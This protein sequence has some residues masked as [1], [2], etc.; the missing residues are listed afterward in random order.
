MSNYISCFQFYFVWIFHTTIS[1]VTISDQSLYLIGMR[2][3]T[4]QETGWWAFHLFARVCFV[5]PNECFNSNVLVDGRIKLTG[6]VEAG[7]LV[8]S[9][10]VVLKHL[11]T[12]F[13]ATR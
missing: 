6:S 3:L 12:Y 7:S 8:W 9:S 2:R 10:L 13:I 11:V 1:F 5:L 4:M